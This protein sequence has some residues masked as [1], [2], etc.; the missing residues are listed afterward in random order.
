MWPESTK[1]NRLNRLTVLATSALLLSWSCQSPANDD[2]QDNDGPSKDEEDGIG[3]L[4]G[5][6]EDGT[7]SKKSKPKDS[8]D[9]AKQDH[10]GTK[11]GKGKEKDGEL[12]YTYIWIANSIEGTISKI[13]TRTMVEEGRHQ[14]RPDRLGSPSRTSVGIS[15]DVV[16]ANR[17]GGVTKFYADIEDCVDRN[18]D[19]MIQTSKGAKDVL[20]WGE[21]EYMAWYN[22]MTY[23][24]QRV[25][26]GPTKKLAKDRMEARCRKLKNLDYRN[27]RGRSP[28]PHSPPRRINR[29]GP[30]FSI[31]RR[32]ARSV[33]LW[34]LW[35]RCG[36]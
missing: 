4:A 7:K 31:D 14:T 20:K 24:S 25:A 22:P 15:G 23:G 34:S 12:M 1:I 29:R 16:V 5:A 30:R 17:G 18:K 26:H 6:N 9:L 19:G 13:N 28:D 8:T 10:P 32:G 21:D 27:P 3:T 33:S 11:P 2:S 35:R 36:S